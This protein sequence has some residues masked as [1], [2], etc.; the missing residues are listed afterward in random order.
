MGFHDELA[1]GLADLISVAGNAVTYTTRDGAVIETSGLMDRGVNM[2]DREWLT[3]QNI[4]GDVAGLWV[5][6][7]DVPSSASSDVVVIDGETWR[8]DGPVAHVKGA[9][10]LRIVRDTRVTRKG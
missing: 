4:Q 6:L 7:A 8:V 3:G 5:V 9:V 1:D 2:D 10:K